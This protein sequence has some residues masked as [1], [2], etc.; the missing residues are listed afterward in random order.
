MKRNNRILKKEDWSSKTQLVLGVALVNFSN[1]FSMIKT[2]F[3]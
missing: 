2:T 1:E 3:L